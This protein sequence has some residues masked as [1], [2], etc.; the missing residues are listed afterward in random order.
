MNSLKHLAIIM[1]GNGRWAQIHNKPRKTGHQEGAKT[2]RNIT[3]WC[4]KNSIKYLTLYAFSTENWKRPKAEVDF[5]MKLLLQYLKKEKQTYLQNDICFKAIGNIEVFNNPLKEMI[6]ELQEL[7]K[8][9][10]SLTQTLA[11]NYGSRDEITRACKK[12]LE[13]PPANLENLEQILQNHLD[14]QDTPDVDLLIRTGGEMR[15]SNFLLWQISYAELY[16][17]KTY[18]PE[19]TSTELEAII[20]EYKQKN[21]RFG[22]L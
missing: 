21:R 9:N 4:A 1:D 19:F 14:T 10:K 17:T 18:W 3:I 22:G 2:V 20:K 7:T 13:N 11:L 15:I 8:N 12:I 6:Y 16:F 5:L